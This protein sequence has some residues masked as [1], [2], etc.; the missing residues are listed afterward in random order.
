MSKAFGHAYRYRH[1]DNSPDGNNR[2]PFSYRHSISSCWRDTLP[3]CERDG[4]VVSQRFRLVAQW[5]EQAADRCRSFQAAHCIREAWT[6]MESEILMKRTFFWQHLK[7]DPRTRA[8]FAHTWIAGVLLVLLAS[9]AVW[10]HYVGAASPCAASD[11][12]YMVVSGDTLSSIAARY[13]TNW[14]QLASYNHLANPSLI[15]ANQA[16]CIPGQARPATNQGTSPA[17]GS[18]NLFAY[19]QCTWWANERY[20]E[21]HGIY[22]PWTTQ[23]DAWQWT[24]R[25]YQFGWHVSSIPVAGSIIDLQPWVQGAYGLGHVA[26][27]EQVLSSGDVIVSTMNWGANPTQVTDVQFAPGPGVTFLWA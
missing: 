10:T 27:V 12:I 26:V 13:N 23:A 16:I 17:Q 19:P 8:L 3:N 14:Q 20:H 25:A 1:A 9:A 18:A 11:Q 5:G 22:V 6:L 4:R 2:D 15:F 7:E 21:L 24:D